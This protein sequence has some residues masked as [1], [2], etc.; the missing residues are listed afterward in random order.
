MLSLFELIIHGLCLF[1]FCMLFT[2]RWGVFGQRVFVEEN[3]SQVSLNNC[4]KMQPF[5]ISLGLVALID[6]L[7]FWAI[8]AFSLPLMALFVPVCIGVSKES[9]LVVKSHW[10]HADKARLHFIQSG[11]PFSGD[12]FYE[13]L[14]LLHLLKKGGVREVYVSSP[15]FFRKN[16]SE[17]FLILELNLIERGLWCILI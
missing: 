4:I 5:A 2:A 3:L 16:K 12:D 6:N 15:L 7:S 13:L 17:S 9:V 8:L 14:A 10:L 11:V 1:S